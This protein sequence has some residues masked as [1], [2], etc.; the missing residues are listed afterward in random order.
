MAWAEKK[1]YVGSGHFFLG[2]CEA[3]RDKSGVIEFNFGFGASS[4]KK[5]ELILIYGYKILLVL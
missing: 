5:F 2:F 1:N 4:E 3:C